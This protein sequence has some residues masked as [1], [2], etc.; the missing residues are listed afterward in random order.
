MRNVAMQIVPM[1]QTSHAGLHGP[2]ALL[3]TPQHR[4]FGYSEGQESGTFISDPKAISVLQARYA[5][6][7]SQA[8]TI[9]DSMGLLERMR[10][11]L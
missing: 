3:E 6:M 11:D 10:G 2:I 7:R 9:Q 4:W 5:R 1:V 8:L